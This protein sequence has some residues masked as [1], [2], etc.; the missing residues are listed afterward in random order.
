MIIKLIVE[1]Q[2]IPD[3]ATVTKRNGSAEYTVVRKIRV[4]DANGERKEIEAKD[5][6]VFL[7]GNGT[8]DFNAYSGDKELVWHA[9]IAEVEGFITG[10]RYGA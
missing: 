6:A 3:R 10:R 7:A 1:A 8:G 5:G 2:Y 9:D 4:F